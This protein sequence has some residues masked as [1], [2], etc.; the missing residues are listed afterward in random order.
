LDLG[1]VLSLLLCGIGSFPTVNYIFAVDKKTFL[2]RPF[3]L[4]TKSHTIKMRHLAYGNF[5]FFKIARGGPR[6]Y[7]FYISKVAFFAFKGAKG[8]IDWVTARIPILRLDNI[9]QQRLYPEERPN[10]RS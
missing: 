3:A 5:I 9:H 4:V 6:V 1:F 8:R 2:Q 7:L 10:A